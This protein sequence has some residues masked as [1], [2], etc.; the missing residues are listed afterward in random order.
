MA[1][2]PLSYLL[3]DELGTPELAQLANDP[4]RVLNLASQY[5]RLGMY[6][7]GLTVLSRDYPSPVSDQSEPGSPSPQK[8][9]MIAYFR[10]YCREKL[11]QSAEADYNA[12]AKLSTAYIF[13]STAEEFTVFA[14]CCRHGLKMRLR[15][16][17][18]ERFIFRE[19]KPTLL[20]TSGRKRIGMDP[21]FL[22]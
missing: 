5:M 2:F 18:S 13:P 10:G 20:S 1:H 12:A 6:Q 8:H 11:G 19:A 14:R 7:K 15:T 3:R 4:N 9:P 17:C 22:F 16:I 21:T